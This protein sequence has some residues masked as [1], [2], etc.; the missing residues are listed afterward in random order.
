MSELLAWRAANQETIHNHQNDLEM[1]LLDKE[2]M[3]VKVNGLYFLDDSFLGR[4]FGASIRAEQNRARDFER[5]NALNDG[6]R[7]RT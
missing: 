3:E 6:R 2:M 4:R 7:R 1:A 5:R